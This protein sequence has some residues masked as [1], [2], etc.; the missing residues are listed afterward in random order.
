MALAHS[1]ATAYQFFARIVIAS[2]ALIGIT[3]EILPLN[4]NLPSGHTPI[5]VGLDGA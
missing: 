5:D 3:G 1:K 4:G 2:N